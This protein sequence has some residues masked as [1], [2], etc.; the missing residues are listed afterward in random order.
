MAKVVTFNQ[1][2]IVTPQH[3]NDGNFTKLLDQIGGGMQ[4]EDTFVGNVLQLKERV[5]TLTDPQSNEKTIL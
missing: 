4:Y 3:R 2:L 5:L 1:G